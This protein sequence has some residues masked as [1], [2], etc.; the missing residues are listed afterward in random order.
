MCSFQ[1]CGGF[2]LSLCYRLPDIGKDYFKLQ[3]Y[4]IFFFLKLLVCRLVTRF[5]VALGKP[6]NHSEEHEE[7]DGLW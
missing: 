1:S 7:R 6:F 3:E 2:P 4:E 5:L